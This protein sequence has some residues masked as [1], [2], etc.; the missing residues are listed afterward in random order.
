MQEEVHGR[1]EDIFSEEVLT[2]WVVVAE[3]VGADGVMRLHRFMGPEGCSE[4]RWRGLLHE[5]LREDGWDDADEEDE[6]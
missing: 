5:G 6:D 2:S 1:L 4:W 3:T